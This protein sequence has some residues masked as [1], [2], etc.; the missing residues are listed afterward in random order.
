MSFVEK[1]NLDAEVATVDIVAKEEIAGLRWV[2][3]NFEELHEIV[4]LAVYITADSNRCIHLQQVG[5]RLEDFGTLVDD[6]ERLLLGQATLPVEVLLQKLQIWLGGVVRRPELLH[7]GGLE[8]GGLDICARA[9]AGRGTRRRQVI[10]VPLMTR[11]SVL[12][13][14]P[15]SMVCRVKSISG[16]GFFWLTARTAFWMYW[17]LFIGVSGDSMTA[18]EGGVRQG[19]SRQ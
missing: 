10:G 13:C 7:G 8:G 3:T 6:P 11:S 18:A 1:T 12:T 15:S 19:R 2:T 4:V 16:T 14:V 5:F 17:S 9:S